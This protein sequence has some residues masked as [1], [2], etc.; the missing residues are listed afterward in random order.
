V[1]TGRGA[2]GN[3]EGWEGGGGGSF[4]FLLF[5]ICFLAEMKR[6]KEKAGVASAIQ[7]EFTSLPTCSRASF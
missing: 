5:V 4:D 2:G 6:K 3:V 7:E 1:E